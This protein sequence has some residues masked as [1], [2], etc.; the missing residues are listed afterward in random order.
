VELLFMTVSDRAVK[1]NMAVKSENF[2]GVFTSAQARILSALHERDSQERREGRRDAHSLKA[3]APAVAQLL[4][5]LI[6][7]KG[8]RNIVEFG[9]SHGY[10]TIHL[11]AAAARTGGHVH[12]VDAL[13]A[14]TELATANL[15][16]ADLLPFV[17]LATCDGADFVK[18]LVGEVDFVLVDYGIPAFAPAFAG[19]ADLMAPGCVVFVDGGPE[20]YWDSG[21]PR[22][23]KMLLEKDPSFVISMLPMHKEQLIAVRVAD[24]RAEEAPTGAPERRP[25]GAQHSMT[26][27]SVCEVLRSLDEAGIPVWLDGGWGVD[28]LLE[29]QTRSHS[30]LD[31]VIDARAT[32]GVRACLRDIGFA[33][34]EAESEGDNFVMIHSTHG[35]VDAHGVRFDADGYG[36]FTLSDGRQWAMPPSAFRGSGRVAARTVQCLSP[37]AQVQ[38]HGQ[39]YEPCPNDLTDMARLQARFEVVL[40][41]PLCRQGNASHI[42]SK[43]SDTGDIGE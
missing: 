13:V 21:E 17:N 7:A 18:S 43:K 31:L 16:T 10:S 5:L 39:G 4:Y 3:L 30:D 34:P 26:A 14:K 27:E 1:S 32:D 24:T 35:K 20:G 40:P 41:L 28:A 19:L 37:E 12:T 9:T 8:A 23:F 6:L 15:R 22:D 2:P 36:S 38:C 25:I 29:E 33:E 11:A 42:D